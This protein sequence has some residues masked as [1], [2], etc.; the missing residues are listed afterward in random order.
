MLH[1]RYILI[2]WVTLTAGDCN[3]R[4]GRVQEPRRLR[5]AFV[6]P[7]SYSKELLEI[8]LCAVGGP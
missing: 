8:L 6:S 2:V 4:S 7:S 3:I 5:F 1:A